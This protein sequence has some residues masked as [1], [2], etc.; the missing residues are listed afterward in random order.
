MRITSRNGF[1]RRAW[2]SSAMVTA[3]SLSLVACGR[4]EQA[5]P[6][7]KAADSLKEPALQGQVPLADQESGRSQQPYMWNMRLVGQ[8]D[9]QNRGENGNLGWI[10]DCA[11]VSAYFGGH[12]PLM[13]M[14]V[15]DASNPKNPEL[16]K[17]MPGT[18]GTR[19]SQV[20]ANEARKI[21][22]V[23]PFRHPKTP[24]GDPPG[25]SQLQIYDASA[26][27]KAPVRVGTY[28]F[29]DVVTHEHRISA[30][31][32]TVYVSRSG[33]GVVQPGE[34]DPGETLYA[35]DIA[36]LAHPKLITTW[37]LSEEPG[38]PK[39]GMHDLD[40]NDEGTRAYTN[41]RWIIDGVRH[42]GLSILDISEV[43]E[44]RPNPKIR[45]ISSFNWGP[46]ENFGGTHSSAYVTIKGRQ[47][48]ICEDE[49]MGT[50][51]SAPWGWA[52]ILDV[53]D[54]KYPLQIS[55]IKMEASE[56]QYGAET[57]PDKAYY[58]AHY[59]GVDD[60]HNASLVFFSWYSSGLR[61]WDIR[62]PY[63]PREIGYYIPGARTDTKLAV[64]DSYP[65]NKVDYVYSFI[66]YRPETGHIWFNSL[67]NGFMIAELVDNPLRPATPAAH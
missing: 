66:R 63:L 35:I 41:T 26:D 4:P 32:N 27:C 51:A 25:P 50:N 7:Q 59:L 47:Y 20:E 58:G 14:A 56:A 10:G 23:M 53:T 22:V 34:R 8:Q 40:V 12:D 37:D 18:P 16:V 2:P 19:E 62:D 49:T 24:Y 54:E 55:T 21:V 60:R 15:I 36:D 1:A 31:G 3:L 43:Q 46:P 38:M 28:D 52:R 57:N 5:P 48:V 13:G 67:F 65:N 64:S 9:I 39:S 6:Q 30:D 17:L 42:Q 61:A 29:G 44:R 33:T 11:Y 45:R